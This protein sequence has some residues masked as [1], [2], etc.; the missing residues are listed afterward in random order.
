MDII[1]PSN[2][3]KKWSD[4]EDNTLIYKLEK[5]IDIETI[6]QLHK[7]SIGAIKIRQRTIAYN[8]YLKKMSIDEII[9]LT[10]LD[11]EQITEA[12]ESR[13]MRKAY[14]EQVKKEKL[15]IKEK[16]ELLKNQSE[17]M[18]NEIIKMKELNQINN[19]H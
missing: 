2:Y 6:A 11:K 16:I 10:R 8:L 7:R 4:Y 17:W 5:N 15:V 13:E 12:I 9:N 19:N 14:I 18:K 1:L 3:G